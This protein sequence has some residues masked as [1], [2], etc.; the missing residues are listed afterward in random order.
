MTSLLSV[1]VPMILAGTLLRKQKQQF[2]S[3][4]FTLINIP[5]AFWDPIKIQF[6]LIAAHSTK[7][8]ALITNNEGLFHVTC[9]AIDAMNQGTL[10]LNFPH[11]YSFT[12]FVYTLTCLLNLHAGLP[13][14]QVFSRPAGR[15]SLLQVY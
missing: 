1:V 12:N 15:F 11:F 4:L 6:D 10:D 5:K 2:W 13:I 9:N 8:R 7:K 14:F 3:F